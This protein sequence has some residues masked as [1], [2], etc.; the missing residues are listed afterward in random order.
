MNPTVRDWA[1]IAASVETVGLKETGRRFG[2]SKEAVRSGVR[3]FR[4]GQG[5]VAPENA[6]AGP[7]LAVNGRPERRLIIPDAHIPAHDKRAWQIMLAVMRDYRPDRT[8]IIGDLIDSA[9]LSHHPK[10]EPNEVRLRDEMGAGN[11]CLDQIQEAGPGETYYLAGNH[12]ESWY[13]SFEAEN[14]NLEGCLDTPSWLRLK[15]RGIRWVSLREQDNFKIGPVSYLHGVYEGTQAARN[16]A[17][18]HGPKVG[19]RYTVFGH[20]HGMDSSTS[21]SGYT[22]RACG[23]LGDE[24]HIAFGYRKGRPSPWVLGF[25]LQEVSGDLVCDTEVRIVG[26]RALVNGAVY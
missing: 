9:S 10:R 8:I 3:R 5:G 20:V 17:L 25:L 24:S 4:A 19:C 12:D 16:H 15:E 18:N 6:P 7:G 26:G 21:A 22:A 14:P 2:L 13:K 11:E 23:F 1:P